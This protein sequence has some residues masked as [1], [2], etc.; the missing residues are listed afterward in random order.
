MID[1]SIP[2]IPDEPI[3]LRRVTV[4]ESRPAPSPGCD[5]QIN[6]RSTR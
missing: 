6:M 3:T 2:L 5:G 4:G 1:K